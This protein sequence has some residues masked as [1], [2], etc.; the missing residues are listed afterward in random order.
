MGVDLCL[1]C[2]R[3][4]GLPLFW[5]AQCF[6]KEAISIP[7]D[8]KTIIRNSQHG[9]TKGKS[10]LTNLIASCNEATARMDEGRAVDIV[11]L[12]FS[13]AFKAVSLNITGKLRKCGVGEWTERGRGLLSK[14]PDNT[15]LGG[16]AD[17]SECCAALQ[18]DPDRLERGAK[19]NHLEFNKGECRVLHLGRNN[20][21]HQHRMGADLLENSS[22]GKNLE[23]LVDPVL[24]QQFV[25]VAKKDRCTLGC[26]EEHCQQVRGYDPVALQQL[27]PSE[28]CLEGCVQFWAPQYK[29][30]SP[31]GTG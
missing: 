20:P 4:V 10:C 26:Q 24:S 15:R 14:I 9:F 3:L 5:L 31:T 7:M 1:C 27:S 8:D 13:K 2:Y 29:N 18:K 25:L 17:T 6:G 11:Y 30:I 19:K 12:H 23:G 28:A 21:R 22:A 16:V